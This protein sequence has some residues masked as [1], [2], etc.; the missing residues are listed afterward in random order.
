MVSAFG[1]QPVIVASYYYVPSSPWPSASLSGLTRSIARHASGDL[2]RITGRV[3]VGS[4]PVPHERGKARRA[5]RAKKHQ[6]Q[7]LTVYRA[8]REI[9]QTLLVPPLPRP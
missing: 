4:K 5:S 6:C 2:G 1:Q 3:R 9:L 8:E 7:D